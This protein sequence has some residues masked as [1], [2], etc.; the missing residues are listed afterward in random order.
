[1]SELCSRSRAPIAGTAEAEAARLADSVAKDVLRSFDVELQAAAA[2]QRELEGLAGEAVRTLK[3]RQ[4]DAD[5]ATATI[6][7]VTAKLSVSVS[8]YTPHCFPPGGHVSPGLAADLVRRATLPCALQAPRLL[9]PNSPRRHVRHHRKQ[10]ACV[11]GLGAPATALPVWRPTWRP[12]PTRWLLAMS[13]R[14]P[15]TDGLAQATRRSFRPLLALFAR[16]ESR[17][18]PAC[19]LQAGDCG[20]LSTHTLTL[21]ET[22]NLRGNVATRARG[23]ARARAAPGLT[24]AWTPCSGSPARSGWRRLAVPRRS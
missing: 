24:G 18:S 14:A 1:M 20:R 9:T 22:P 13:D 12:L 21:A 5:A 19:T 15:T 8:H 10:L 7:T 3:A 11:T 2:R 6:S 23:L 16:I 4:A 17:L